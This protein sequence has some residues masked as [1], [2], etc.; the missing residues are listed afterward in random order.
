MTKPNENG[1]WADGPNDLSEK[2]DLPPLN[3]WTLMIYHSGDSDLGE[4][5]IWA[6]KEMVRVGTPEGVEVIAL[7]DSVSQDL[8][9]FSIPAGTAIA[10][11]AAGAG[12]DSLEPERPE[13]QKGI[14]R[15]R[16][17]KHPNAHIVTREDIEQNGHSAENSLPG[18]PSEK[19]EEDGVDMAAPELLMKFVTKCVAE[20]PAHHYMLVLSGHGAGIIGKTLLLDRGAGSFLS[21]SELNALLHTIVRNAAKS[22]ATEQSGV[23]AR[24]KEEFENQP[25]DLRLDILGFDAC[26]M[27]SAEVAHL[28]TDEVKYLVASEGFMTLAGWPYYR[29]LEF[30]KTRPN[31][32][33]AELAAAVVRQV[34]G[35][36]TDYARVGL[37]VDLAFCSLEGECWKKLAGA[38][39]KLSQRLC[40]EV[41]KELPKPDES[42]VLN[43]AAPDPRPITNALIAAHWHAQS[44]ANEEFVDLYDF[45]EQLSVTASSPELRQNCKD[46]IEALDPLILESCYAG[47]AFQHSHGMSLYFP[48][49]ATRQE[50]DRYIFEFD[51]NGRRTS[52]PTLFQEQTEW[53]TFLKFFID[54]TRRKPRPQ[55]ATSRIN[56]PPDGYFDH[57]SDL[58]RHRNGVISNTRNG[59]PPNIRNGVP[60]N[61]RGNFAFPKVKS[62]ALFCYEDR[63]VDKTTKHISLPQ[64]GAANETAALSKTAQLYVPKEPGASSLQLNLAER[65]GVEPENT[66]GSSSKLRL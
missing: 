16:D 26:V 6:M 37:S 61:T 4:E 1:S 14:F 43:G 40:A 31:A 23:I 49:V 56:M 48:W 29:I 63:G 53:G 5:F 58:P 2:P 50:L 41:E 57:I 20:H 13:L 42:K 34:V 8:W 27:M 12:G 30:L 21:L 28:L 59:V 7:M 62:P 33:P 51:E 18:Y 54:A 32:E 19:E 17:G 35:Y 55:T 3:N 15:Q 22:V 60:S 38:I 66:D 25:K 45:C 10:R 64:C 44:Y 47:A 39:L 9:Q 46:I 24:Y 52:R 36:Y 65:P 11:A